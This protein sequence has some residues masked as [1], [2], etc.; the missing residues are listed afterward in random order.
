MKA[1][2]KSILSPFVPAHVSDPFGLVRRMIQSRDRAALFT[3]GVTLLGVLCIPLDLLLSFRERRLISAAAANPPRPAVFV[4]GPARS[5][6]T[7]VFQ[8]LCRYLD[9]C[10]PRNVTAIFP[11]SPI[12][13]TGIYRRLARPGSAAGDQYQNYYGKTSG[14]SGPSEANHIWHRWVQPDRTGFRTVLSPASAREAARFF[15]AFGNAEGKTVVAKNNNLNAFADVVAAAMPNALIVCVRRKP[16]FLAQSLLQARR[17]IHGSVSRGYGVRQ[18]AD[19]DGQPD[20]IA[21]VCAQV[22]YLERMA[23]EMQSRIGTDRFW[24]VDYE[25][26]C[27]APAELVRAIA[28]KLDVSMTAGDSPESIAPIPARNIVR[29]ASELE[30]IR[31]G[32]AAAGIVA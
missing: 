25:E 19:D 9:V 8:V 3:L 15:A 14:M 28:K 12:V 32:L 17:D 26:F 5:G 11:R 7:L 22:A 23:S 4:C 31:R 10:F 2:L 13:V 18:T 20:P 24:I 1:R 30:R 6:T 29:D 16:E 27:R 21:S